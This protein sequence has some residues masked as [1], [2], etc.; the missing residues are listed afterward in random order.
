MS[1]GSL[2]H[3]DARAVILLRM[4]VSREAL[5]ATRALPAQDS[6]RRRGALAGAG[7]RRVCFWS[8]A[9]RGT[10]FGALRCRCRVW[11]APNDNGRGQVRIDGMACRSARKL[12]SG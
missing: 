7:G 10:G 4:E 12:S 8:G 9:A 11:S 2:S 6:G 1:H 5:L 3:E